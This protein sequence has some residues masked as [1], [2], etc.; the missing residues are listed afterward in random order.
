MK[1]LKWAVVEWLEMQQTDFYSDGNF[2]LVPGWEKR[3]SMLR[4]CVEK[5]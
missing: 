3:I 1:K 5:W 4:D 2:K